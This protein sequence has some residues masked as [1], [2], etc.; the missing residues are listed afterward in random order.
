MIFAKGSDT[1]DVTTNSGSSTSQISCDTLL[2]KAKEYGYNAILIIPAFNNSVYEGQFLNI[3]IENSSVYFLDNYSYFGQKYFLAYATDYFNHY[4]YSNNGSAEVATGVSITITSYTWNGKEY[5]GFLRGNESLEP[6][7]YTDLAYSH[8]YIDDVEQPLPVS[9]Q[10]GGAG[11]GYI[12]NSLLSNKKMVGYNVPTSSAESTY[13]ESV[14]EASETPVAN[15]PKI[16]NGFARI[17]F[18]REWIPPE[19]PNG[20]KIY[21]LDDEIGCKCYFNSMHV[22]TVRDVVQIVEN[23]NLGNIIAFLDMGWTWT[24]LNIE[25]KDFSGDSVYLYDKNYDPDTGSSV[26][27]IGIKDVYSSPASMYMLN[28]D[29]TAI[30]FSEARTHNWSSK[31]GEPFPQGYCF[32]SYNS[33]SIT[34]NYEGGIYIPSSINV[35]LNDQLYRPAAV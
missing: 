9:S 35:Y 8:A 25:P 24:G 29:G 26:C 19:P 4:A 30:A 18:L 13:T 16:G 15:K 22:K 20:F 12:G 17:K 2:A 21:N 3:K 34:C 23:A 33:S 32:A 10:G 27:Y 7:F 5:K 14:N 11:S 28:G 1:F 6:V 31:S